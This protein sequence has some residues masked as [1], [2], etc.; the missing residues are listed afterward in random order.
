MSDIKR[1]TD[2]VNSDDVEVCC[3]QHNWPL[4]IPDWD[5]IHK[6][7][8]MDRL[9]TNHPELFPELKKEKSFGERLA[10]SKKQRDIRRK[11][12]LLS[13]DDDKEKKRSKGKIFKAFWR[14]IFR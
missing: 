5:K 10:E 11:G 13:F 9:E 2:Y 8:N 4:R 7:I 1:K 12:S 3:S 14:R 6:K